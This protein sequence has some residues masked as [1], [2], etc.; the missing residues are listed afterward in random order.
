MPNQGND[1][2]SSLSMERVITMMTVDD[3]ADVEARKA[4]FLPELKAHNLLIDS[5][6]EILDSTGHSIKVRSTQ[7]ERDL[8]LLVAAMH[9]KAGKTY[10][11]I[12]QLCWSGFGED[13]LVLL[14]SNINLM[15]NLLYILADDSVKRAG[16]L[17]AYSHRE[18]VKYLRLAHNRTPEWAEKLNWDEI[19]RRAEE[20]KKMDIASKAQN[21]KQWFHY[22][23]G[24][25]F[26]SSIEHADA[27][28][29]SSL[30][31]EDET[32]VKIS[33]EPSDNCISI[34]LIHNFGV[35]AD[36]FLAFCSHFEIP[37]IET[38]TKLTQEWSNLG[39]A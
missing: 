5:M 27:W 23:V 37:Y 10:Q 25:R 28:A 12:L 8:D 1:N 30:I 19:N 39:S 7:P 36:I 20:W 4:R 34:A 33:S 18:Q 29:L 32:E 9:G 15:I 31:L 2:Y 22:D 35:M 21:C 16:D 14:R 24:Y 11:A 3:V 17:I 38:K 13:A 6:N 26:Y